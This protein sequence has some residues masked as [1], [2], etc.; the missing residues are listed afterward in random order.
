MDAHTEKILGRTDGTDGTDFILSHG[1][2]RYHRNYLGH[3]DYTDCTDFILSRRSIPSKQIILSKKT[4]I[5]LSL[6]F[7]FDKMCGIS[8]YA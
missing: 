5:T 7:I 3:T 4:G 2:H 6:I 8:D 1:N